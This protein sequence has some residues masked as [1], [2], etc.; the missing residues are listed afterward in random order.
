MLPLVAAIERIMT[1]KV[2]GNVYS[3]DRLK[4]A[5]PQATCICGWDAFSLPAY[6]SGADGVV[7]GSAAFMPD[8]EVELH[9]LAQACA[10][11]DARH[12]FYQLMLPMIAFC[13]PDPTPSR[14]A[15]T[16]CTGR[17]C[18]IPRWFVRPTQTSRAGCSGNCASWRSSSG[19]SRG[20]DCDC[21]WDLSDQSQIQR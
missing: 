18:S 20:R 9:R 13:T 10:W 4:D 8:R 16:S 14:C 3:F 21:C 1:V 5:A 7:A 2:S 6:V 12:L 15:S 19:C 17:A 11:D